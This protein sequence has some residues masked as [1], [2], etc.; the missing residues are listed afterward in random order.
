VNQSLYDF[1]GTPL[2]VAALNGHQ[3]IVSMLKK[4]GGI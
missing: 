1:Y 4:S 3:K 2:W